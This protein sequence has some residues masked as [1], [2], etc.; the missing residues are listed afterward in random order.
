MNL[1]LQRNGQSSLEYLIIIG[2]GLFIVGAAISYALYYSGGY[3]TQ[4]TSQQLQI[5]AESVQNAL[6]S[7]SSSEVGS[8]VSFTF[9]SPGLSLG[10]S[11]CS[12]FLSFQASSSEASLS[13]P[14]SASGEFPVASGSYTATAYLSLFNGKP[15]AEIKFDLPLSYINYSY[16]MNSGN[17]YYNLSFYNKTGGLLSNVN[18]TLFIYTSA[19]KLVSAQNGSAVSG[20]YSSNIALPSFSPGDIVVVYVP[21][22]GVM[23]PACVGSSNT[24]I[25]PANVQQYIP[26]TIT[27]SQPSATPS[28]FQQLL[29][30][31]SSEYNGSAASNLDNVEFFYTNGTIIPS[32]LENYTSS[33]ALWWVKIGGIPAFSSIQIYMGFAPTALSLLNNVNDG[34]APQLSKFPNPNIVYSIPVT[35]TNSQTSPTSSPFQEML[36]VSSSIYSNYAASNL[37]NVEFFYSNGSVVTSWLEGYSST[38]AVWWLKLNSIPASSSITVYMDFGTTAENFFNNVNDGEAP[39]LSSSYGEYNNIA[40]VMN[41]GLEYQIYFSSAS[42]CDSGGYQNEVYSATLNNGATIDSCTPMSSSTTQF[43]TPLAGTTEDVTSDSEPNVVINYQ[44]GYSGGVTY[45]NPPVPGGDGSNPWII[46]AIGWAEVNSPTEFYVGSDDGIALGYSSSAYGGNGAY[47][48]GGTSNPNNLVNQW[49]TEGFTSYSGEI[50]VLGT[51]RIE[52]DYYEDGGGSYTALWSNV[53]VDYYSPSAPPNGVMPSAFFGQ[54]SSAYGEYD[55]GAN[56]FNFYTDFASSSLNYSA[57]NIFNGTGGGGRIYTGNGLNITIGNSGQNAQGEWLQTKQLFSPNTIVDTYIVGNSKSAGLMET[58]SS[59]I[60]GCV[61]LDEYNVGGCSQ[62]WDPNGGNLEGGYGC[63]GSQPLAVPNQPVSLVYLSS[64]FRVSDNYNP[65]YNFTEPSISCQNPS[66]LSLSI[67]YYPWSD[68]VTA[69]WL[70]VDGRAYPPNG[71]M[72]S[73]SFGNTYSVKSPGNFTYSAPVN[74]YNSQS[75][76]TSS[77]FQQMVKINSSHYSGYEN[78]NLSNIEFTYPNGTIIPSWLE[79]GDIASFSQSP[80]G[81]ITAQVANAPSSTVTVSFWL[82]PVDNG[83]WGISGN[84]WEN[85]VSGVSNS[86]GGAY[87]FFIEAGG[88]PPTESWSI[89]NSAGDTFRDFPGV[90][91]L[92]NQWQQFV[93]VYNGTDLVVYMNGVQIGNPVPATGPL[94]PSSALTISGNNP[95]TSSGGCNPIS[96]NLADVQVY[97]TA[98]SSSQIQELYSSGLSGGPVSKTNIVAWYPLAGNVKDYSGNNNNGVANSVIYSGVGPTSTNTTYWL[99]LG[100]IPG[101]GGQQVFMDFAPKSDN[102]FNT[103]NTGEAPLLSSTYGEYD[104]G[105]NVFLAYYNMQNDPISSSKLGTSYYSISNGIGPAGGNYPL[106]TWTGATGQELAF[107]DLPSTLPSSFIITSWAQTDSQAYDI[108]VGSGSTTAGLWD[109]YAADPGAEGN[110]YLALWK[111]SGTTWT[112]IATTSYSQSANTW[113]TLEFQYVSGGS[114]TGWVEPFSNTLDVSKSPTTVSVSDTTYT[115]FNAIELFP[116]SGATSD[117][118]HWALIA[119]RAYPPNGVMPSAFVAS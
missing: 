83:Y 41:Q 110:G 75:S 112:A 33:R 58:N 107:I 2:I 88:N 64:T 117:I 74:I 45:P 32:W 109:G 27:N 56:V 59:T 118:T 76:A 116:Y 101:G 102:L 105:A 53:T 61:V 103:V 70:W 67:G 68:S 21:S 73:V 51:Q 104:D 18:F 7:L 84:Y 86:C 17:L 24:V 43:Y 36:N 49:H 94:E 38:H 10:S 42:S 60:S 85:A 99:K 54:A 1:K 96:G 35:I 14:I 90:T 8:S 44:E 20:T 98:L 115:S 108:G 34:E 62:G 87:Y 71:V 92:P 4:S 47:W 100:S 30:V 5:A 63:I 40:N 93:G 113:Y 28:P 55:D 39:Q 48:L 37:Q 119:A 46:K 80:P 23:S 25:T 81:Y 82:R 19:H 11:L 57:W 50:S 66:K 9:Q 22:Y 79:S 114:I 31:S 13:L 6:Q 3:S 29:N 89:T 69:R 52:L 12:Q 97:N 26:I 15:K 91:V 111:T 16:I 65:W 95:V 77:P 72:P 78:N 106:L